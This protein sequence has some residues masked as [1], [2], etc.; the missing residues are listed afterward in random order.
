MI[1]FSF[2]LYLLAITILAQ[3]WTAIAAPPPAAPQSLTADSQPNPFPR[4]PNARYHVPNTNVLVIIQAQSFAAQTMPPD[5]VA[6]LIS[7][8]VVALDLLAA[9]AG[10]PDAD[11]DVPRIRWAISGLVIFMNDATTRSPQTAGGPFRFDELRAAYRGVGA[12]AQEIGYRECTVVVW[13]LSSVLRR[14]VK[15][16]GWGY[17]TLSLDGEGEGAGEVNGTV[18]ETS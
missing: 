3:Q 7:T 18:L 5:S 16:L 1:S 10:G 4:L 2:P 6:N 8:G 14:Q 9:R 11:L 15:F 17:V 13:R 12:V